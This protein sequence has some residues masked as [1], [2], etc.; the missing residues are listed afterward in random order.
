M[1][2]ISGISGTKCGD[3]CEVCASAATVRRAS[4]DAVLLDGTTGRAGFI[5][6]RCMAGINPALPVETLSER[7]KREWD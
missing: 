5:P 2:T 6:A 1:T 4:H 7:L 3:G